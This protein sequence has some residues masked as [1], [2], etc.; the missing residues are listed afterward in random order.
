MLEPF[1]VSAKIKYPIFSNN[2]F[3]LNQIHIQPFPFKL[4]PD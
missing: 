4:S 3:T 2:K 1:S